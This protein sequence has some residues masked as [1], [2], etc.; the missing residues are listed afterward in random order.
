MNSRK[1]KGN[2]Q[3]IKGNRNSTNGRKIL[4]D[5]DID[6]GDNSRRQRSGSKKGTKQRGESEQL[7][8]KDGK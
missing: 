6:N 2:N 4:E 3:K 8:G 7:N 1:K 5:L